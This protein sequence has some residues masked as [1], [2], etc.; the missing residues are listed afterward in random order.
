MWWLYPG[1]TSR[2]MKQQQ[3]QRQ[4]EEGSKPNNVNRTNDT[5]T[6]TRAAY[7]EKPY[8]LQSGENTSFSVS[9]QVKA[10]TG[11]LLVYGRDAKNN[12]KIVVRQLQDGRIAVDLDEDQG[13]LT[14]DIES[15]FSVVDGE[16]DDVEFKIVPTAEA[17]N[18]HLKVGTEELVKR[19]PHHILPRSSTIYIGGSPYSKETNEGS[20]RKLKLNGISIS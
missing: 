16:Y 4:K 8:A 2:S 14:E 1:F 6:F 7:V 15:V 5:I 13:F 17:T 9:F 19:M 12:K 3:K 11:P 10:G 18:W 20:I